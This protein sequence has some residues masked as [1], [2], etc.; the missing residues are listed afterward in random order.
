MVSR[1]FN[2]EFEVGSDSC[3]FRKLATFQFC[4]CSTIYLLKEENQYSKYFPSHFSSSQRWKALPLG[5]LYTEELW[6]QSRLFLLLLIIIIIISALLWI[7]IFG[8]K[9]CYGLPH[10]SF[11][12]PSIV[13][14]SR[15]SKPILKQLYWEEEENATVS[16]INII[17]F[18]FT[19]FRVCF[20]FSFHFY[21]LI[22][23]MY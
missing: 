11:S 9:I 15:I 7:K 21:S 13:L 18:H 5:I 10:H 6:R 17:S 22:V 8:R 12:H 2:V 3:L 16:E 19:S 23:V 14:I 1:N 20:I 4:R